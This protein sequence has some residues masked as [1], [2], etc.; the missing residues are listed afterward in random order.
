LKI[1]NA[2]ISLSDNDGDVLLIEAALELPS[3][4]DPSNSQNRVYLYGGHYTS[5]PCLHH[6]PISFSSQLH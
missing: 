6:Q 1:P 3:W 5:S 2:V 4:L